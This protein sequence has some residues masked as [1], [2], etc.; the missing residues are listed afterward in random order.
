MNPLA[1]YLVNKLAK[2]DHNSLMA[3]RIEMAL[4]EFGYWIM[5]RPNDY[6]WAEMPS[7][8]VLKECELIVEFN[9]D[10]EYMMGIFSDGTDKI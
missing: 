10:D 8:S 5:K 1:R 3:G 9:T 4:V 7:T 6:E 2:I